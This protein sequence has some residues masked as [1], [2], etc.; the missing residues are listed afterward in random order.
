MSELSTL[1]RTWL[2]LVRCALND[3]TPD[4]ALLMQTAPQE[5]YQLAQA[6]AMLSITAFALN[7]LGVYHPQFEEAKTKALRKLALYDIERGEIYRALDQANIWYCPLKGIILKDDYPEFGMREMTDNDILCDPVRMEDVR[8]VMENLGYHC[9]SFDVW[10]HDMYEKEPCLEFEMHRKLFMQNE[11]PAL[12]AYYADIFNRL[13]NVGDH[14]YRFSDEDFYI[15]LLAHEYKHFSHNGTGM[16]SLADLYVY[17]RKHPDMD[18]S[19]IEK[20]LAKLKLTAFEQH[21]RTLAVKAF[22][23]DTL[24]EDET[25]QLLCFYLDSS[26]YGTLENGEYNSLTRAF[27]GRDD[28]GVKAKYFF[29]RFFL[30]GDALKKTYPF[31]YRHKLLRP[32]LYVYRPI[33]GVFTHPKSL[34]HDARRVLKYRSPKHKF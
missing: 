13:K 18:Q 32:A 28:R 33:K 6:H 4:K 12:D 8:T 10:N 9:T 30:S 11:M 1:Q 2:H 3:Q 29:D 15:Y 7:R 14:E 34:L 21:S 24:S 26:L 16:R 20:E 31:F 5:I 22:T 17:L 23:G 19:Y 25:E 27:S